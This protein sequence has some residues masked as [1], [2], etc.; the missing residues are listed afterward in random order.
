MSGITA[1][2]KEKFWKSQK[3][4]LKC[5]YCDRRVYRTLP[6][7]NPFRATI[8]HIKPLSHGGTHARENLTVS[9]LECNVRLALRYRDC[10]PVAQVSDDYM[11]LDASFLREAWVEIE[12]LR[13]EV[14]APKQG[15]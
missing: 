6:P 9:C 12:R 3:H 10:K 15:R 4:P 7:N 14:A 5:T 1:S 11:E 13:A 8:D 2:S